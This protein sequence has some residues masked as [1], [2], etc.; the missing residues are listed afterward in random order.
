MYLV[1][2]LIVIICRMLS[3][4]LGTKVI[5]ISLNVLNKLHIQVLLPQKL[6]W[7]CQQIKIV[8]FHKR[9]FF[10][11]FLVLFYDGKVNLIYYPILS[12]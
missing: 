11:F 2:Q 7:F 8:L 12:S 4:S 5:T 1:Q 9:F 6:H 10:T 3:V